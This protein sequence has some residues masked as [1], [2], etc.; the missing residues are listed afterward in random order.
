MVIKEAKLGSIVP[1]T[2]SVVLRPGL[3]HLP[4][5][6]M[7]ASLAVVRSIQWVTS[8][9]PLIKWPN[10]VLIQGKKASGML[11]DSSV[12]GLGPK[13]ATP[14]RWMRMAISR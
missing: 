2:I 1:M 9:K 5:L 11:S 13:R 3:P 10:D 12:R 8:L 6:N 4:K 7:V 14:R